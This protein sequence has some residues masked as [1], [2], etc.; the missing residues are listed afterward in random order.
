EKPTIEEPG[1][2]K[3]GGGWSIRVAPGIKALTFGFDPVLVTSCNNLTDG[4]PDCGSKYALTKMWLTLPDGSQVELRDTLTQGAPARTTVIIDGY[5][6]LVD[7]D[8]GRVWRSV[9]GSNV[10]FVRDTNDTANATGEPFFPSGWVFLPDGSR[11]RMDAG[12]ASR[13]IDRNGNFLNITGNTYTDQLGR[14]TV[15]SVSGTSAVL[16]VMGYMGTPNR[17]ISIDIGAI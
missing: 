16:T 17:S 9:D 12:A 5:H 14:Q 3:L 11:M 8:R 15:L 1:L 6:A 7:R 10:I 4:I 13:I 2:S